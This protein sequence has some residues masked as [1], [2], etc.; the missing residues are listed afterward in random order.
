[1]VLW[2]QVLP[3]LRRASPT[4]VSPPPC[5]PPSA[6]SE[7]PQMTRCGAA[8]LAPVPVPTAPRKATA[9]RRRPPSP[10]PPRRGDT[11]CGPGAGVLVYARRAPGFA[12][13][14]RNTLVPVSD[15]DMA[16][17]APGFA[18]AAAAGQCNDTRPDRASRRASPASPTVSRRRRLGAAFSLVAAA[19]RAPRL[20]PRPSGAAERSPT[21][22]V[23][24]LARPR[25]PGPTSPLSSTVW[26]PPAS[27]ARSGSWSSIGSDPPCT[28]RAHRPGPR[29]RISTRLG[30]S[31]S[32]SA[33][34]TARLG[35]LLGPA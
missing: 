11:L 29:A 20:R 16:V 17:R 2:R 35:Q 31:D 26:H 9:S 23:R 3:P 24:L 19:R 1:M 18:P 12:P 33:T 6:A 30:Q 28:C 13:G 5:P 27:A 25:P 14:C 7:R 10:A 34:R 4:P 32:D 15:S 8:R 21:L 22:A